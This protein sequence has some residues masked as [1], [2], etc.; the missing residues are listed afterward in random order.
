MGQPVTEGMRTVRI[1][2][3]NWVRSGDLE[4]AETD[5]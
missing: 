4:K 3:P 2:G 1:S 5:R